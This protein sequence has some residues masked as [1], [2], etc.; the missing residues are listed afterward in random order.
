MTPILI[1]ILKVNGLLLI[2][3][4]FYKLFLQKE[5]YVRANRLYFLL[6]VALSVTLPLFTY[7]KVE[8][9]EFELIPEK[10]GIVADANKVIPISDSSLS[11]EEGGLEST[12]DIKDLKH[13]AVETAT[14]QQSD[15]SAV[16]YSGLA[17]RLFIVM[18]GL[19]LLWLVYKVQRLIRHIYRLPISQIDASV[20][21]DHSSTDAYSFLRWVVLPSDYKS[22][23]QLEVV[24]AHE[25]VHVRQWHS[26]DLILMEI[27]KHLFWF[28]P[29]LHLLQKEVNLNLEYIVDEKIAREEDVY[30]Y[31]KA[32]VLYESNK[33]G[34]TPMVNTFGSSDLKKRILMLNNPKSTNM[35]RLKYLLLSPVIGG[36]F[37]LFQIEVQA[38]YVEKVS[39]TSTVPVP[40]QPMSVDVIDEM[41]KEG[42]K[43]KFLGEEA[44]RIGEE[45]K[46]VGE[47]AKTTAKKREEI[48]TVFSR[49]SVSGDNNKTPLYIVDGNVAKE[50]KDLD[51]STIESMD[52][53]KGDSATE[54]YGN[55]AMNGAVVVKLKKNIKDVPYIVNGF[56]YSYNEFTALG[57]PISSIASMD[58]LD[59]DIATKRYGEVG[60]NGA[61]VVKLKP[62]TEWTNKGSFMDGSRNVGHASGT[63]SYVLSLQDKEG[64]TIETKT[65]KSRA[66]MD[67]AMEAGIKKLDKEAKKKEIEAL[68]AEV[69]IKKHEYASKREK[70]LADLEERKVLLDQKLKKQLEE[71]EYQQKRER[72][73]LD[74]KAKQQLEEREEV[75]KE[76][77]VWKVKSIGNVKSNKDVRIFLDGS[78]LHQESEI[79]NESFKGL[80]L[81]ND[82]EKFSEDLKSINTQDVIAVEYYKGASAV[83]KYGERAKDGVILLRTK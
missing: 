75:R 72:V 14:V 54:L 6:G 17:M 18:T 66:E 51:A 62:D 20:R 5:T 79:I 32:L 52:I 74:Q 77:N 24:L 12:P 78:T 27:L 1:Y 57:N 69:E 21:I 34:Y 47:D 42:E 22:M 8:T 23:D 35:R 55:R 81:V 16:D 26:G 40:P 37:F 49:V 13:L 53:L 43:A 33:L 9:V 29:A 73:L 45:A 19:S 36:F 59:I 25:R 39:G 71:R 10:L 15:W 48:N 76:S 56:V 2:V 80:V 38:Q 11:N 67:K 46:R 4:L 30:S 28:N 50:I 58:V 68:K 70:A 44:K 60:K 83:K 65:Y 64:N 82:V 63:T 41:I 31:Q 7:T 61:I 3:Y